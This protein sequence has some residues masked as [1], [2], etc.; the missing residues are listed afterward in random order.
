MVP[1]LA[2]PVLRR[3]AGTETLLL[4][5]GVLLGHWCPTRP[6]ADIDFLSLAG[7][8]VEATRAELAALLAREVGDGVRFGAPFVLSR[9]NRLQIQHHAEL[10][11]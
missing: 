10:R 9:T 11:A 3:V 4:R 8:D 7:F 2:G 6:V 1:T 5:G